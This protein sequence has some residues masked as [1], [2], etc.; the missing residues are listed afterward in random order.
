MLRLDMQPEPTFRPRKIAMLGMGLFAAQFAWVVYNTYVPIFLQT[1]APGFGAP[2]ISLSHGFG[3]NAV[4]TGILM[5]L[6]NI[7]ALLLQPL[8]GMVSDYTHTALGGVCLTFWLGCPLPL[9]A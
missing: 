1:G 4:Q 5:T 2:G 6:D 7:A 8:S 3:L 9:L